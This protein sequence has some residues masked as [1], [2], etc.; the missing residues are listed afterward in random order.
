MVFLAATTAQKKKSSLEAALKSLNVAVN[1][2]GLKGEEGKI[3]KVC[4]QIKGKF[5]ILLV[6][7]DLI[8]N[9]TG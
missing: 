4:L 1:Y 9:L 2:P 5:P 6:E 8:M 3:L 7:N